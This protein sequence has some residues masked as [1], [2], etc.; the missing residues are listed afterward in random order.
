MFHTPD[1]LL[2]ADTN[3]LD[4]VYR[5]DLSDGQ[6]ALV[7]SVSPGSGSGASK[8]SISANGNRVTYDF[9]SRVFLKDML[10]GQT[11]IVSSSSAGAIG[12][13]SQ[14]GDISP[15]GDWVSFSSE[16]TNL[17]AGDTDTTHDVYVKSVATGEL[18]LVS[19]TDGGVKGNDT[20][21]F[22]TRSM[23]EP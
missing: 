11:S 7:S 15:N 6:V 22:R 10:S 5:V 23:M 8:P 9:G 16:A 20:S 21:L 18:R 1:R 12:F 4:D 3:M 2:P 19:Q 14:S 13:Y 17:D